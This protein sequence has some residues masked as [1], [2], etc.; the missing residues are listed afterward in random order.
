MLIKMNW[1]Q[2]LKRLNKKKLK[3]SCQINKKQK[4]KI[5]SAHYNK[6]M[7]LQIH[8]KNRVF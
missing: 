5:N 8:K 7:G 4:K 2:K 1:F 6:M 3:L